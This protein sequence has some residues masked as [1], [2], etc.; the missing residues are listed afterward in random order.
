MEI[1][2]NKI[3]HQAGMKFICFPARLYS[4]LTPYCHSLSLGINRHQWIVKATQQKYLAGETITHYKPTI[5][6]LSTCSSL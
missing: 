1:C 3:C 6:F 5:V 2:V 4:N